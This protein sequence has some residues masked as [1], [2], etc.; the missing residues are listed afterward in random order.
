VSS[1]PLE[2]TNKLLRVI[3]ALLLR[4]K[5]EEPLTLRQRVEILSDL[6]LKPAEIASVL[7]RTNTYVN[8]ELSGIRKA[9]KK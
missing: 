8:K 6:G 2:L 3:V 4:G 5:S 7:G 9:R 1:E